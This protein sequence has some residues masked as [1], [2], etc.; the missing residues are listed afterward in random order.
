LI[1]FCAA[2][3]AQDRARYYSFDDR[4]TDYE[5]GHPDWFKVSFFDLNEDLEEALEAGKSGI[6]VYFGQAHCAYCQAI[7]KENLSKPDLVEYLRRHFDVIGLNVFSNEDLTDTDGQATTVKDYAEREKVHF[8]PSLLFFGKDRKLAL[9]LRGYYPAYKMRAAL[10]FVADNHYRQV[11]FSEYL[12]KADPPL[13]FDDEDLTV[14]ALFSGQ[15]YAL[16]RRHIPAER[17]LL[18]IFEQPD[19]HACDVFHTEP[20]QQKVIRQRLDGY[21]IVQLNVWDDKTPVLTPDGR[22]LTPKEWAVQLGLFYTPTLVFF[23]EWG[24]EVI[25]ID[26]VLQFYRLGGVL[27]Y[28]VEKGYLE[29]PIYHQWARKHVKEENEIFADP[30]PRKVSLTAESR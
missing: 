19:C 4:L 2:S 26:S 14:D 11:S 20:L 28:V 16:D 24:N 6:I 30:P 1:F 8:T 27:R 3:L 13:I 25:R 23:D 9:K 18:V 5:G 7:M 12:E 15:P 29:E 21:E 22:K 10:E 17:P